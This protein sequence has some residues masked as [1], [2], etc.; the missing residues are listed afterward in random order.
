MQQYLRNQIHGHNQRSK[1]DA[2]TLEIMMN[3]ARTM[4]LPNSEPSHQRHHEQ[5]I[6]NA[7]PHHPVLSHQH[8]GLNY[9]SSSTDNEQ[10]Y[11]P[12]QVPRKQFQHWLRQDT[13]MQR[14]KMGHLTDTYK[15]TNALITAACTTTEDLN[16]C[17]GILVQKAHVKGMLS[18]KMRLS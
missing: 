5:A 15:D 7:L 18:L 6:T 11:D 14:V 10:D 12:E 13:K 1:T 4:C 17:T 16:S 3:G 2:E 9:A 8:G